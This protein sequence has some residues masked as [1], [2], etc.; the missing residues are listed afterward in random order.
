MGLRVRIE[1]EAGVSLSSKRASNRGRNGR[2]IEFE[3]GVNLSSKRASNRVR[4]GRQIE[5]ETDVQAKI[6]AGQPCST[7][8]ARSKCLRGL[9]K[10]KSERERGNSERESAS[11]V[12]E[13]R[14][15]RPGIP[16]RFF[17]NFEWISEFFRTCFSVFYVIFGLG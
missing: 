17:G 11:R 3:A 8:N 14:A 9:R 13:E 5:F 16:R 7:E 10:F 4:N 2:Q 1:F 12:S 15:G 6:E